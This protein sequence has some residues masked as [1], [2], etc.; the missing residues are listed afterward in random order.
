MIKILVVDDDTIVRT[1]LM[2]LII[3]KFGY[4]VVQASNG[5]EAL[6]VLEHD[7]PDIIFLDISMPV[8]NG[9]EFLSTIRRNIKYKNLPVIA[10]TAHSDKTTV[11]QL[12]DIGIQEFILKPLS[13]NQTYSRLREILAEQ[14]QTIQ[15]F[16]SSRGKDTEEQLVKDTLLLNE[17]D[18]YFA[19]YLK[20]LIGH[21]FDVI[22]S[23]STAECLDLYVKHEPTYFIN[24][25]DCD[26]KN[27][28]FLVEKLTD[29]DIEES[30]KIFGL[31]YKSDESK[32][33]GY[34]HII[35][36]SY[37]RETMFEELS[38]VLFTNDKLSV[39]R[40]ELLNKYF[41]NE[42]LSS[43]KRIINGYC[44]TGVKFT[45][46]TKDVN[47]GLNANKSLSTKSGELSISLKLQSEEKLSS[48]IFGIKDDESAT[49]KLNFLL[50]EFIEAIRFELGKYGIKLI[51]SDDDFIT[52]NDNGN[53]HK[54]VFETD[55][56]ALF[57]LTI[58]FTH[59]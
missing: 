21:R 26:P 47:L 22:I 52:D 33:E 58:I 27:N 56:G 10:I 7:D 5:V 50:F 23:R 19:Q 11:K 41:N 54:I 17:C 37:F 35:N 38:S 44:G 42:F 14:K 49:I 32:P 15:D 36:K 29:L 28:S 43:I 1:F 51:K 59:K 40:T 9:I 53:N 3:N 46:E 20:S 2:K 45:S 31:T 24:S 16:R 34:P 18:K 39:S 30:L 13:Y 25:L 4:D 12:V 57:C 48:S 8:M 55:S 6:K